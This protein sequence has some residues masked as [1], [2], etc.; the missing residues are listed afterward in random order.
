MTPEQHDRTVAYTSHLPQLLSTAL[1]SVLGD[2]LPPDQLDISGPALADMTRLAM[3]SFD[4]WHDI[5]LT[6][7]HAIDHA[8]N[9]YIDKLTELR[10]NLQT[11]GLGKD[12]RIAADMAA[13][14]RR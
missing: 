6:N 3:S 5:L 12:F 2:A 9:V 4:V 13:R 7:H 14:L 8:L 1:A 10:H 11:Q